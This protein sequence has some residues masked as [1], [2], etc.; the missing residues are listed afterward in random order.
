MK[1]I[2]PCTSLVIC[3]GVLFA[4]SGLAQNR[5]L[6]PPPKVREISKALYPEYQLYAHVKIVSV[7]DTAPVRYE[8]GGREYRR[9]GYPARF[10]PL[11]IVGSLPLSLEMEAVIPG[12]T[13]KMGPRR[14]EWH[15]VKNKFTQLKAGTEA[16]L[17]MAHHADGY[18]VVAKV[19]NRH[20]FAEVQAIGERVALTGKDDTIGVRKSSFQLHM[21]PLQKAYLA[22]TQKVREGVMTQE[23]LSQQFTPE[24]IEEAN[25]PNNAELVLGK[26]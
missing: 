15:E 1:G 14:D 23:E 19:L 26:E 11:E 9:W 6:P 17:A 12:Y 16:F 7:D 13:I 3:L 2:V 4:M 22:A 20:D 5:A 24:M 21:N 25:S 10:A 18:W 8:I